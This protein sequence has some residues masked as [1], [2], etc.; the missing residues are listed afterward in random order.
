[1]GRVKNTMKITRSQ[2]RKLIKETIYVNRKG[3]AFDTKNDPAG[4]MKDFHTKDAKRDFLKAQSDERLRTFAPDRTDLHDL[5]KKQIANMEQGIQL[6]DLVGDQGEF[7]PFGFSED[8]LELR[9]YAHDEMSKAYNALEFDGTYKDNTPLQK[10]NPY[11]G[12]RT[13]YSGY[14]NQL[15]R[16]MNKEIKKILKISDYPEYWDVIETLQSIPAYTRLMSIVADKEGDFSPIMKRLN[17]LPE[18]V[19]NQHGVFY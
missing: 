6:A 19:A 10:G 16:Q 14:V 9:D 4:Y 8:E 15:E 5:D 11:Y 2:L 18:K 7:K 1:M 12:G 13:D 17:G 3:D